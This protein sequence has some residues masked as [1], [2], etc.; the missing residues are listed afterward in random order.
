M[1]SFDIDKLFIFRN[2]SLS[3]PSR[4]DVYYI[5]SSSMLW[6]SKH[7]GSKKDANSTNVSLE[8]FPNSASDVA[9]F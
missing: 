3:S 7:H 5:E 4:N 2:S 1:A 8:A 6:Y 9:G